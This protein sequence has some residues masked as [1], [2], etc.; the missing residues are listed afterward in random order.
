MLAI[1]LHDGSE[2]LR[3]VLRG[4]LTG[5]SRKELEQSW[6]TASSILKNKRLVVDLAHLSEVDGEGIHLLARMSSAG[7]QLITASDT[8]DRV[9]QHVSGRA[10][11]PIQSTQR[12]FIGKLLCRFTR[13]CERSRVWNS[14]RGGCRTLQLKAW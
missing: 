1:L 12:G 7:A 4:T 3:F 5:P 9:A 6:I 10:P 14:L 2:S 8:M 13:C 11:V